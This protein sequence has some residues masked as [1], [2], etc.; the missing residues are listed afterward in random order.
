MSLINLII[1]IYYFSMFNNITIAGHMAWNLMS[2][3]D[4]LGEFYLFYFIFRIINV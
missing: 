2:Y 4:E 3:K 1:R